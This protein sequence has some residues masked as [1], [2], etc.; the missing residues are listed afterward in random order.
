[1]WRN[2][3]GVLAGILVWIALVIPGGL[4]LRAEWPAYAAAEPSMTFDLSMK[5]ARLALSSVGLVV[6]GVVVYRVA[7]P[8]RYAALAFGTIMLLLFIPVHVQLWPK[9]PI[10]YHLYFLSSLVLIP[11][12]TA[13]LAE[14][15]SGAP[16]SPATA[17]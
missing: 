8:S 4:L 17:Q 10:W 12:L 3:L 6:A 16:A 7:R 11:Q 1:M 2:I 9:F 13:L 5:I 14:R 15:A